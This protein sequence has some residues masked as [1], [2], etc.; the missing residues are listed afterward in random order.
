MPRTETML[1]S[2]RLSYRR[3]EVA[4]LWIVA[5]FVIA[6][7]VRAA[8]MVMDAPAPWAW[9]AA[10]AAI[11]VL[12]GVVWPAWFEGGVWFWNG[13]VRH[14]AIW[15]RR[16]VLGVCYYVVIAAVGD[17]GAA[18]AGLPATDGR[19]WWIPRPGF[20]GTSP[21]RIDDETAPSGWWQ[22]LRRSTAS[23]GNAWTIALLPAL[24][25]LVLLRDEQ[26][27]T[28]PPVSTYTLY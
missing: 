2:L 27:D 22:A 23:Q 5:T 10:I 20:G 11:L 21:V 18:P 6:L 1:P 26:Q 24:A 4:G 9:G 16:Y 28:A 7:A 25:L 12:P 14:L 3:A 13:S 19:S 8:A 17:R 15:L